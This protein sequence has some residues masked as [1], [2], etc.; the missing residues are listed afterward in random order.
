MKI[1]YLVHVYIILL[2]II[3]IY[4]AQV[5]II[6]HNLLHNSEK[7]NNIALHINAYN[8]YL[9]H[10]LTIYYTIETNIIIMY[11]ILLLELE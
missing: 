9:S 4:L 5:L 1:S 7:Y 3:N 11:C 8:I 6:N 2:L 10:A